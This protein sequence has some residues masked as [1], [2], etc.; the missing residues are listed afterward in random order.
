MLKS[1]RARRWA[2][3]GGIV[4]LLATIAVARIGSRLAMM[5][6]PN[7][8]L[9]VMP[10]KDG[11][12]WLRGGVSNTGFIVGKTS[13]TAI[14]AQ[15]F[16]DTARNARRAIASVT[17]KPV[18]SMI[19]THSDPDHVNG[20]TAYPAVTDTIA[21]VN[22]RR[23]ILEGL[24]SWRPSF[25]K[26]PSG[27]KH[28]LPIRVVQTRT[29]LDIDGVR[30]QLLHFGPAHTD[31]DMIVYLPKQRV[32]FA[33]DILTPEIGPFP[34][35][36]TEKNGSSLGWIRFVEEMLKLDADVF[37][38]G[39]GMPMS[40]SEIRAGLVRAKQRRAQVAALVAN[41]ESLGSIKRALNDQPL[42]GIAS[43]FPTFVETTYE[44][45]TRR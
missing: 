32:V 19:I 6:D 33:G 22:A 40:V 34:G 42:N 10:V 24:H 23:D 38:S 12:Y 29:D 26:P 31:G 13:V 20:L 28:Y 11:I 16:P 8:P 9:T 25:T 41:K 35:I 17:P 1:K 37:V 3:F 18:R 5:P 7:T 44:E 36:H 43:M 45:L 4:I 39:H 14:D 15:M 21:Q 2:F 27:L 30:F